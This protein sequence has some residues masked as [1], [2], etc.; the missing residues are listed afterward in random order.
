VGISARSDTIAIK[1]FE[2]AKNRFM[3][4][5]IDM[6]DLFIAQRE[7]D[8]AFNSYIQTL[9]N[10]WTAYFTIRKLT[11]FDFV[12]NKEIAYPVNKF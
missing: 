6:N 9:R 10:F 7:K 2:I 5:K 3:I 8:A 4:G 1:R 11:L 12:N